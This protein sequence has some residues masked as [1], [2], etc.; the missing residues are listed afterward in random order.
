MSSNFY[1]TESMLKV[2]LCQ[3]ILNTYDQIKTE[4]LNYINNNEL[5]PHPTI[6]VQDGKPLYENGTWFGMVFSKIDPEYVDKNLISRSRALSEE[7]CPITSSLFKKHKDI[8]ANANLTK[9]SPNT[10]VNGH[11]EMTK[12]YIR[13]QI[14]IVPDEKCYIQIG[15]ERKT[16]QT[17]EFL[18]F[19]DTSYHKA[20]HDGDHDLVILSVDISLKY[21]ENLGK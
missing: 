10:V 6:N 13:T 11:K 15:N 7:K 19:K 2:P 3:D 14:A 5:D 16:W 4:L 8:L 12:K 21:F 20:K 9:I 1:S 17:N 18:A